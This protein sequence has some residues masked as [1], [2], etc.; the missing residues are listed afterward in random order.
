MRV[1]RWIGVLGLGLLMSA[2]A[3]PKEPPKTADV[4][5]PLP[6]LLKKQR[7]GTL[8]QEV[9]PQVTPDHRP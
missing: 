5:L 6:Y 8:G 4:I 1:W 7:A 3:G 2:C 9:P